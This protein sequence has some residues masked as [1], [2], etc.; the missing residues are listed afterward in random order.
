VRYSLGIA[1]IGAAAHQALAPLIPNQKNFRGARGRQVSF[2]EQLLIVLAHEERAV[3]PGAREILVE[4]IF[5]KQDVNHAQGQGAVAARPDLQPD[6]RLL[7]Y[8][9]LARIDDDE[10]GAAGLGSADLCRGRGP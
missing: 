2:G 1:L 7:G 10:L 9:G 5:F 8:A 3:G 6:I 4:E